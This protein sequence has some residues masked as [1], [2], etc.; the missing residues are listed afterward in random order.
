MYFKIFN[1]KAG[2]K[3]PP[4]AAADLF[5]GSLK[6]HELLFLGAADLV[7]LLDVFVGQF[8]QV[9]F[10]LYLVVLGDLRVLLEL[11]DIVHGVAADIA[12]G[13]LG[14][15]AVL[16]HLLGQFLTAFLRELGEDQSDD[17]AVVLGVN[18][19]IGGLDGLFDLLQKAAVPGLDDQRAGVGRRN[20]SYLA[21][22]RVHAVILNSDAIQ[23]AGIGTACTDGAEILLQDLQGLVHLAVEFFEVD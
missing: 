1:R 16:A 19:Q 8:L 3:D 10:G 5:R 13:H 12:D 6:L 17:S 7:D 4:S 23:D 20:S 9:L 2:A 22:G 21:D 18:A 11:L 14:V 15:L